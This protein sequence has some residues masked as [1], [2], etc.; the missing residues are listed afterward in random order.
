MELSYLLLPLFLRGLVCEIF[1]NAIFCYRAFELT[2]GHP[3]LKVP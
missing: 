1:Q 2:I 3:P